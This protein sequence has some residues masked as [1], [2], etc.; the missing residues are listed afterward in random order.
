MKGKNSR[1]GAYIAEFLF[2][3][4]ALH[5]W[6][7][8]DEVF[9]M[10]VRDGLQIGVVDVRGAA[11]CSAEDDQDALL[12]GVATAL[13]FL[14]PHDGPSFSE[15]LNPARVGVVRATAQCWPLQPEAP[16]QESLEVVALLR[17]R[18]SLDCVIAQGALRLPAH[19]LPP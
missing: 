14:Y 10:S 17:W 18:C 4:L 9:A 5:V 12:P 1:E 8:Q 2:S 6:A 16:R 7:D 19:P 11:S 3:Q 13:D 15:M